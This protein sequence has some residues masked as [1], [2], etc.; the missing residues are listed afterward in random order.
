LWAAGSTSL[1]TPEGQPAS[2]TPHTHT[3][4]LLGVLVRQDCISLA[5]SN[6]YLNLADP[7]G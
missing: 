7:L 3:Q 5:V 6:E 4:K 2:T 1:A